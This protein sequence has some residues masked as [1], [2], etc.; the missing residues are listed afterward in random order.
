MKADGGSAR[1]EFTRLHTEV[2]IRYKFLSKTID[3]GTEQIFE[4]TTAKLG[5]VGCLLTGRIPSFNW[6]PALLLGK[7]MIG[8]NM[9]LPSS[10]EPIKALC[11]V[12]WIEA[13]SEG[14][15][16]CTLGIEFVDIP[17]DCEDSITKYLIKTQMTTH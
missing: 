14:S 17:K 13:M 5:G 8:V 9:L 11:K 3:L 10:D 12:L 1:V 6:I 15:D 4:G 2:P 16:R 7:I